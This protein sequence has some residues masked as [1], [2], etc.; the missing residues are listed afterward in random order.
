MIRGNTSDFIGD[1][2][3]KDSISNPHMGPPPSK[4]GAGY[5]GDSRFEKKAKC[6]RANLNWLL[7]YLFDGFTENLKQSYSLC[8]R[9]QCIQWYN[10]ECRPSVWSA[11]AESFKEIYKAKERLRA[12]LQI[13]SAQQHAPIHFILPHL[14]FNRTG[15]STQWRRKYKH[16]RY[17]AQKAIDSLQGYDAATKAISSIS[18]HVYTTMFIRRRI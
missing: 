3:P 13:T 11:P 1:I 9:L 17:E 12:V 18:E 5:R 6:R 16:D 15:D 2:Q 8:I 10:R 14:K 4:S 7:T